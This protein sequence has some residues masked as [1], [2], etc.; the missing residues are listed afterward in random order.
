MARQST[1]ASLDSWSK[2]AAEFLAAKKWPDTLRVFVNTVLGEIWREAADEVDES[3]LAAH[4]EPMSL[5]A[6]PA[7]VLVLTSGT[8]VQRDRLETAITGWTAKGV[9]IAL[10]QHVVWGGPD[11]NEARTELDDFL[12][13]SRKYPLGGSLKIDAA[14]VDA[15]NGETMDN[16][17]ASRSPA[18]RAA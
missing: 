2:L 1:R 7:E 6:I 12:M 4:A 11:S 14:V 9:M 15:G 18:S 17:L 13:A 10:A 8:D 5:E 3:E 16:V